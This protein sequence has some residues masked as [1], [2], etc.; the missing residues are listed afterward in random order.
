MIISVLSSVIIWGAVLIIALRVLSKS[1]ISVPENKLTSA[2]LADKSLGGQHEASLKETGAVFAMALAFRIIVFIISLC[3]IYMF[4]DNIN[5]VNDIL[6]Q[7][8]KWDANNYIRIATGGYSYYA[9]TGEYSTLAFFPLYPWLIKLF[10]FIFQDL[11]IS[12]LIL[13]FLLYSASCSVLYKLFTIDYN[14]NTAVRA[15]IYMS[16][17]PHALFFG[18]IMNESMLL[19]TS[20]VTLYYIREHK[21]YLVGIFGALAALSRMAGILLA[22]PAAVEW[23]EEYKIFEKLKN[24]DIKTV[25]KLFYGKGLW[26]FLMLL[27][28]GIYLFCNYKTTGDWFKFLEYQETIWN[29]GSTYFGSCINMIFQRACSADEANRFSIWIPEILSIAFVTAA[30]VYGL[31]RSRNMY[32]AFL[33]VYIIINAGFKWPISVARYMA[34]AIPAFLFLSDFSERH[35]WTE[36]LITAS[37]AVGLGAY[38]VAYLCWKQIL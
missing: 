27:G 38:L 6:E 18:T 35:K 1:G 28:T 29:N 21:W 12:G 10:S 13:S 24:K 3:V 15:I 37:M 36:P 22:I 32:S 4:N 7:Y 19:F 5:S 33:A 2:L 8:M 14:K 17:F 20:A 31:R 26:I 34:C 25:W 11:R 30:L 16:V 23:L 9:P